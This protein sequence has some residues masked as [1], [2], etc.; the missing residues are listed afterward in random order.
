MLA[1]RANSVRYVCSGM[2][3]KGV[4]FLVDASIEDNTLFAGL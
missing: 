4:I 3:K 1:R 2:H